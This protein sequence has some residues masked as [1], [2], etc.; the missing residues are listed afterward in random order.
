MGKKIVIVQGHPDPDRGHFGSALSAA[1][2]A[3]ARKAG[4]E[5]VEIDVRAR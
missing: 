3:G 4:H 2:A 1:Y 5:V